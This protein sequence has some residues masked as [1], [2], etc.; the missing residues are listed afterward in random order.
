MTNN[1]CGAMFGI[2]LG[3]WTYLVLL[4]VW[5]MAWALAG[6]AVFA[7]W[8]TRAET[9]LRRWNRLSRELAEAADLCRLYED[10]AEACRVFIV[11]SVEA[12]RV[13]DL[14]AAA[15]NHC[16]RPEDVR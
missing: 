16:G 1:D 6:A 7:R 10:Q 11:A 12:R 15:N 8:L 13:A 14:I 3:G 4:H 9:P 5:C 2:E